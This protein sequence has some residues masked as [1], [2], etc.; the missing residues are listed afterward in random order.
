MLTAVST[1]MSTARDEK[2]IKKKKIRKITPHNYIRNTATHEQNESNEIQV[3]VI[4]IVYSQN[5]VLCGFRLSI[6]FKQG[7]QRLHIIYALSSYPTHCKLKHCICLGIAIKYSLHK[8]RIKIAHIKGCRLYDMK[9]KSIC[10][11][12]MSNIF[13]YTLCLP[14]AALLRERES[15]SL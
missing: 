15:V 4:E 7:L 13:N 10:M 9:F 12:L 5:D 3:E 1:K 2:T 14:N 6:F 11:F 8:Q